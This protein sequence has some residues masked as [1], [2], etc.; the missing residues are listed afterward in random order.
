[1]A[2]TWLGHLGIPKIRRSYRDSEL[3]NIAEET[4]RFRALRNRERARNQYNDKFGGGDH[5]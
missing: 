2:R 5:E 3:E 1:M 4:A